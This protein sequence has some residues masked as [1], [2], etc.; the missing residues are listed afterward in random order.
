MN[1]NL[2]T[3]RLKLRPFTMNDASHVYELA[4]DPAI[5]ETTLNIPYPYTLEDAE[6]WIIMPD[7]SRKNG[8]YPFAIVLKEEN[9]LIGAMTIGVNQRHK[10]GELAY[11]VGQNYWGQ[12]Y[13]TEAAERIVQFG[14]QELLLHKMWAQALTFNPASAKVMQKI[15]MK[16]EG[17]LIDHFY[18][19]VSF[20]C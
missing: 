13:A 4:N 17:T 14:I 18:K 3:K 16:K 12:G 10:R 2:S 8:I 19:M 11:W 20:K 7:D 1:L 15:G 6:E 5:T 9:Q